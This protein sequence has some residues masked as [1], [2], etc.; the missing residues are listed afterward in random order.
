MRGSASSGRLSPTHSPPGWGSHTHLVPGYKGSKNSW[1]MLKAYQEMATIPQRPG[2]GEEGHAR[3]PGLAEAVA[4]FTPSLA[5][6]LSPRVPKHSPSFMS[7]LPHSALGP[8]FTRPC[9]TS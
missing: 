4:S 7:S 2:E 1:V 5:P 3:A 8:F 9:P 6:D